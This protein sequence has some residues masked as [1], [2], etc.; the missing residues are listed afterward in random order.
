MHLEMAKMIYN[1]KLEE[2][3][4]YKR[5]I[6][7]ISSTQNEYIVSVTISSTYKMK[8]SSSRHARC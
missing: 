5:M 2:V 3:L 8:A 4:Y 7:R 1:L 6:V